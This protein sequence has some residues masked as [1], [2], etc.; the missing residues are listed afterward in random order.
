MAGLCC[1]VLRSN[2]VLGPLALTPSFEDEGGGRTSQ[3]QPPL[4]ASAKRPRPRPRPLNTPVSS[5]LYPLHQYIR[6]PITPFETSHPPSSAVSPY[7]GPSSFN[8]TVLVR[9]QAGCCRR[10]L[11]P[12]PVR[13]GRQG[14]QISSAARCA[15]VLSSYSTDIVALSPSHRTDVSL[16]PR[17]HREPARCIHL[18][19]RRWRRRLHDLRHLGR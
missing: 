18:A 3:H 12:S 14:I 15:T 2:A 5:S 9:P 4:A 6:Y 8:T 1:A 11:G 13:Y 16:H 17:R 10:P 7:N 19:R